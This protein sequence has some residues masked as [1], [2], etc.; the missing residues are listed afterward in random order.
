MKY[1]HQLDMARSLLLDDRGYDKVDSV[2]FI[3]K[4]VTG[5]R[6]KKGVVYFF[7][8][9]VKKEDDW[10]IGI[11]GLQ[12]EDETAVG[13]DDHLTSMTDK[14]L[15]E[16]EPMDEQLQKLLKKLLFSLSRSGKYFFTTSN[17]YERMRRGNSYGDE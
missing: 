5:Y 15:K 10:K 14:K 7:K 2:V 13:S 1:K 4:Q 9:R 17:Y 3:K 16:D 6:D 11:S 8:Y 12:P